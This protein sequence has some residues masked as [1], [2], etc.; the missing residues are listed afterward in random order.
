ML[1][2]AQDVARRQP[3]LVIGGGL[4]A[5]LLIGRALKSAG[6]QPATSTAAGQDWYAA[7]Y[8]GS[9]DQIRGRTGASSGYGTGYGASYD[10][11][12]KSGSARGDGSGHLIGVMSNGGSDPAE[13]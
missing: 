8:S 1:A 2:D 7:G 11:A 10:Q 6:S 13:G 3:A 5:G 9:G 12:G 4:V